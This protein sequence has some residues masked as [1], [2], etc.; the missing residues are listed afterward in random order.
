MLLIIGWA[1]AEYGVDACEFLPVAVQG[2]CAQWKLSGCLAAFPAKAEEKE[3]LLSF[4]SSVRRFT[5]IHTGVL[6]RAS[7]VSTA[8]LVACDAAKLDQ[9]VI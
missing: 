7:V 1:G 4:L 2:L 6:V 3:W 9:V 5:S 8:D